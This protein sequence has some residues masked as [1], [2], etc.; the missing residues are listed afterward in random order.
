MKLLEVTVLDKKL[1]IQKEF[2]VYLMIILLKMHE[3]NYL[4]LDRQIKNIKLLK[5]SLNNK[6]FKSIQMI[7]F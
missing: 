5:I 6:I 1:I 2:L 4:L 7:S 3:Y